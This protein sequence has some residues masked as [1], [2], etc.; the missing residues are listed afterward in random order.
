[1]SKY[2]KNCSILTSTLVGALFT[3]V[4]ESV[5]G[6]IKL[7]AKCSDEVNIILNRVIAAITIFIISLLIFLYTQFAM[8]IILLAELV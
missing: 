2:L 6:C 5:F 1:M 3:L 7:F 8:K 4:P